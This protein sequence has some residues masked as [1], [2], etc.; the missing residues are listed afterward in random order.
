MAIFKNIIYFVLSKLTFQHHNSSL[1][2]RMILQKSLCAA[3]E[4]FLLIIINIINVE[5]KKGI[6]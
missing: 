2:C 1:Q 6:W 5:K 4:T 3:Q